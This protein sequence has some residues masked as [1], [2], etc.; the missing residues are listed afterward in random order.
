MDKTNIMKDLKRILSNICAWWTAVSAALLISSFAAGF[1]DWLKIVFGISTI[2][3]PITT[4]FLQG[5]NNDLTK[6]TPEQLASQKGLLPPDNAA[7]P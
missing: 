6:K 4:S 2:V 3:G 1:P 5:L 7:K